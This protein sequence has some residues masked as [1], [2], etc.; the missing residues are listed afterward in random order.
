MA[1]VSVIISRLQRK[2]P[3]RESGPKFWE[4]FQSREIAS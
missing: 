4:E 3:T 1:V 2:R